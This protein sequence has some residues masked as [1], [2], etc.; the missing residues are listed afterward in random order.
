LFAV[1]LSGCQGVP[2]AGR[3]MLLN[4]NRAYT[5]GE[6]AAGERSATEFLRSFPSS[7][8]IGEAYYLRG[9][10][11]LRLD[12]RDAARADLTAGAAA[13]DQSELRA[14]CQAALADLAY[15][16]GDMKTALAGYG[17]AAPHL[18]AQP[19]TDQVLYRYGVCL[20]RA[21]RWGEARHVFS[22]LLDEFGSSREVAAARCRFAWP[23]DYFAIQ[24]GTFR[25]VDDGNKA[26]GDLRHKGLIA[27]TEFIELDGRTVWRV[28][29]G[30][31]VTYEK[32]QTDLPRVRALVPE[33]A[34]VP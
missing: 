20:Q 30:Q 15:E 22:R 11:R 32:A 2:P 4:A 19:P 1:L 21:G 25:R 5:R 13:A 33:A 8:A 17:A 16:D 27:S 6:Y 31:Y 18:P 24:C 7:S 3:Q 14:N 26:A 10:C 12:Q 34:I 28:L 9:L 29:T 23:H